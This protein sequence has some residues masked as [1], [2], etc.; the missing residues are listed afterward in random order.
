M[1]K[2]VMTSVVAAVGAAAISLTAGAG[3]ASAQPDLGS[4]VDTTCSYPQVVSALNAEDPVAASQ[5]NA[6]EMSKS[7]LRQFLAAAPA[8]RQLMA[9]MIAGTPGNEQ[10]FGLLQHIFSTCNNY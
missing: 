10:Y 8:Q 5:F 9:G 1:L 4:F 3:V 2:V 6:S 7:Y